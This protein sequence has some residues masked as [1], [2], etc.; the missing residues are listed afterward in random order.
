MDLIPP[1]ASGWNLSTLVFRVL[2]ARE[3]QAWRRKCALTWLNLAQV[4]ADRELGTDPPQQACESEQRQAFSGGQEG[5][6]EV[7]PVGLGEEE[8]LA[9]EKGQR[10]GNQA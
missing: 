1:C 3:V 6:A 10:Q 5:E 9:V 8:H 7:R 4:P 2:R